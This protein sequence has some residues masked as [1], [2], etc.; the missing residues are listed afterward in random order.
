MGLIYIDHEQNTYDSFS[1]I[2][3]EAK[4]FS[5]N[6]NSELIFVYLP[7]YYKTMKHANIYNK[8]KVIDLVKDLGIYVIDIDKLVFKKHKDPL[9]LFPFKRKNHYSSEGY[10]LVAD[11]IAKYFLDK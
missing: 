3:N 1:S 2:L 9:S 11:E 10:S 7:R 5:E 8:D 6:N 4:I